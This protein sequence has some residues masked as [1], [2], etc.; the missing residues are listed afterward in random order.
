M[1]L[2]YLNRLKRFQLVGS[3]KC[4]DNRTL[5]YFCLLKGGEGLSYQDLVHKIL[6]F[7]NQLKKWEDEY[8]GILQ[9]KFSNNENDVLQ[10]IVR[11][12]R[13]LE[14]AEKVYLI[15]RMRSF[16]YKS[17]IEVDDIS[18][19]DENLLKK[20]LSLKRELTKLE[21]EYVA[22]LEAEAT[23]SYHALSTYSKHV[24]QSAVSRRRELLVLEEECFMP[25]KGRISV[26]DVGSMSFGR[27]Q[28]VI[29]MIQRM[30][31][32]PPL[33]EER[34]YPSF[35]QDNNNIH[36][37]IEF[38]E[39]MVRLRED[40]LTLE[41]KYLCL[42]QDRYIKNCSYTSLL[43]FN[44]IYS[45]YLWEYLLEIILNWRN[46]LT[47]LED[48]YGC[49]L[50]MNYSCMGI[51]S[52]TLKHGLQNT[53]FKQ[54]EEEYHKLIREW[55]LTSHNNISS[56]D[57]AQI[58]EKYIKPEVL[59]NIGKFLFFFWFRVQHVRVGDRTHNFLEI[60]VNY[61]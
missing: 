26:F 7:R 14:N 28:E 1:Q 31:F 60:Y 54:M 9:G 34:M 51:D 15:T 12:R 41:D 40:F 6:C 17:S 8:I 29:R 19:T 5:D 61:Y 46:Y 3:D 47:L 35:M 11:S 24:L 48:S 45:E 53:E 18:F 50:E 10:E 30:K 38:L 32:Y 57:V 49:K 37:K 4:L 16:H 2:D 55:R 42:L 22:L 27:L 56:I 13:E 44:L 23:Y 33:K 36:Y 39:T 20:M 43:K 52:S 25:L 59:D 21:G 58:Y